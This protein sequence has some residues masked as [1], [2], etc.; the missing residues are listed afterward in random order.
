[1]VFLDVGTMLRDHSLKEALER[2]GV[3]ALLGP[4]A[5]QIL[6]QVDALGLAEDSSAVLV[7]LRGSLDAESIIN[8]LRAP[9]SEVGSESYGAFEILK[10]KVAVPFFTL[11]VPIT[12][13]DSSTAIY[14]ISLS[15]KRPSI[16]VVKVTLD[17]VEGSEP[18]FLL[19]PAINQLFR[20]VPQGFAMTFARDCSIFGEYEGCTG[21]AMSVM[22]DGSDGVIELVRGFTSPELAQ[23]A[24]PAIREQVLKTG[25]PAT[26]P[27]AVEVIL[28]GDVVRSRARLDINT[29]LQAALE[30][31]VP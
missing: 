28:E 26:H 21:L 5:G 15:S 22:K 7:V 3:L 20:A 16:E 24:L 9:E 27:K 30:K 10:V 4:S 18:G 19:D 13:L 6:Q 8:T 17:A 31:G 25:A 11:T 1:M 23:A 29:A 12:L 14:A 2:Q